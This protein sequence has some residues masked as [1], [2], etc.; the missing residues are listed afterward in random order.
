MIE[1]QIKHYGVYIFL[2]IC[3]S[4]FCAKLSF[5]N[6][7]FFEWLSVLL[8]ALFYNYH[9]SMIALSLLFFWNLVSLSSTRKNLRLL[10][11][12]IWYII[13]ILFIYAFVYFDRIHQ[14][15]YMPY[16]TVY[17]TDQI[18]FLSLPFRARFIPL[19]LITII[20]IKW[21]T[22]GKNYPKKTIDSNISE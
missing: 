6:L 20:M 8:I 22:Q 21:M 18:Y 15:F 3:L 11:I 10:M 4:I 5:S 16:P 7:K 13:P 17:L 1:F 19:I 9:L 14:S 12:L 2:L